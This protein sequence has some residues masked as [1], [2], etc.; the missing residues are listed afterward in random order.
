M[1]TIDRNEFKGEKFSNSEVKEIV[2]M[3][4]E[5]GN[6]LYAY[7]VKKNGVSLTDLNDL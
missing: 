2:M 5:C 1:Y 3:Q 7:E 4:W 6:K